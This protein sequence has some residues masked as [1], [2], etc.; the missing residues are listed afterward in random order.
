MFIIWND[1]AIVLGHQ[2]MHIASRHYAQVLYFIAFATA[3]C[4]P[5]LALGSGGPKGIVQ[6]ALTNGLGSPR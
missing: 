1:G 2:E 3:L 6:R 5:T 4:W